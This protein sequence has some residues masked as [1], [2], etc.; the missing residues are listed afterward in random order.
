M[1]IKKSIVISILFLFIIGIFPTTVNA[2]VGPKPSL[3][4][5]VKGMDSNN[6]WL[7]LLV[8]DESRHSW[9]EISD[10]ELEMVKK[11]AEYQDEEGFH[12]AL[13]VGTCVPLSGK[14]KGE[15]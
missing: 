2:D 15:K 5:I 9:L 13:L 12:P 8:T 4:I 3:D 1:C 14:L 10:E 6:Y 11:L 7:D